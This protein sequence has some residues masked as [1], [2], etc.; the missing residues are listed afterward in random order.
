MAQSKQET[1]SMVDKIK[2]VII[3]RAQEIIPSIPNY[4]SWNPQSHNV[5][6]QNLT[7]WL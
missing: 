5:N 6:I 3:S 2:H 1:Y 7:T 4:A